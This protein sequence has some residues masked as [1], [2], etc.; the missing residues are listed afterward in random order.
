[1]D[2]EEKMFGKSQL[3]AYYVRPD[4]TIRVQRTDGTERVTRGCLNYG[5]GYMMITY[6]TRRGRVAART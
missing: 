5:T 1:M 6:R 3:C 4:G 2:M